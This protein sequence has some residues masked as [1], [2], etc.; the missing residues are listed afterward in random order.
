PA[1]PVPAQLPPAAA[2]PPPAPP[3]VLLRGAADPLAP[4]AT[5]RR[6]AERLPHT[7]LVL[8]TDGL[9]DVLNDV[10]HRTVAAQLVQWLERLRLGAH[11]PRLL[12]VST[13]P[14][15]PEGTPT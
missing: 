4:A 8:V 10:T 14:H 2:P 9:H 12:T 15:T 6:L 7:E 1:P 13:T 11:L 5:A 3:A